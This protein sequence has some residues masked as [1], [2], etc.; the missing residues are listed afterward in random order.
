MSRTKIT[1]VGELFRAEDGALLYSLYVQEMNQA[2]WLEVLA[3]TNNW[4]TLGPAPEKPKYNP[5]HHSKRTEYAEWSE[6][7]KAATDEWEQA[8]AEYARALHADSACLAKTSEFMKVQQQ[9]PQ[10]LGTALEFLQQNIWSS[11]GIWHAKKPKGYTFVFAYRG[12]IVR[13]ESTDP[14]VFYDKGNATKITYRSYDLIKQFIIRR[15]K[16]YEKVCREIEAF[17]NVE[18]LEGIPR[19]P[20]PESVR[21]FVWQRDRGQCVKCGSRERLEFDHIIP[22]AAGGS[23]TERNV[24]LLCETCNRSKGATI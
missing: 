5:P 9:E 2:A 6:R 8:S 11:G 24:Q 10:L 3:N 1:A 20:I 4:P 7:H 19:E 16:Q 22:I 12:K 18:K 21:L 14:E 15:E 23:N 17:E 13:V